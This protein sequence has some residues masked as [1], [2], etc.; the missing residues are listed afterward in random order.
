MTSY[1]HHVEKILEDPDHINTI[2]CPPKALIALA[3]SRDPLV[4]DLP[5][6]L[7]NP[8]R[9]CSKCCVYH[10]IR[11]LRRGYTQVSGIEDIP[12][13]CR[14]VMKA[15]RDLPPVQNDYSEL[16]ISNQFYGDDIDRIVY[17]A[18]DNMAVLDQFSTDIADELE[19]YLL[20]KRQA[21]PSTFTKIMTA[22]GVFICD[23]YGLEY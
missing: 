13:A 5:L 7:K 4:Y 6:R 1:R 12:R 23:M 22:I 10:N 3:L 9:K 14:K 20:A 2:N 17:Y 21:E 11:D 16:P 8:S 19:N 15:Y 18:Y